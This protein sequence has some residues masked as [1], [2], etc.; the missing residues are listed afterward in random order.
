MLKKLASRCIDINSPYCPC[1][2][3]ETNHC[4]FCSHLKGKEVCDCNWSGVCIL[5]EKQWQLKKNSW[6]SDIDAPVRLESD[7]EFAVKEK[8]S[9]HTYLLQIEVTPELAQSLDKC[10]SFVFLRRPIDQQFYHFP[11]GVMKVIGNT[12]QVVVET[13]GPKSAR[14]LTNDNKQVLV[15]GPYYN[16]IFGQPWIDNIDDGKILLIV[17][18]IGQSPAIPIAR[19]LVKKNNNIQAIVAPGKIGKVFIAGELIELGI[20]V[21]EVASMRELG[22]RLLS[23]HLAD[24]KKCP[25]LVV[26]SGPDD[27]HYGIIAAMH[28]ARVSLPMAATN[29]ATMCCGEG[30]CGSCERVTKDNKRVRTCKVQTDFS[31]FI[32][33]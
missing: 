11:A 4:T 19:Q 30:I 18:G 5:Y 13:I 16:G 20:N 14:L 28:A 31:Q 9:E 8:I 15:R 26:S 27:Q 17:G 6:L 1:L 7:T 22:I 2:L 10:G 23:E 12:I 25:E 24:S 29:N 3:S 21:Q 32:Q 33:E